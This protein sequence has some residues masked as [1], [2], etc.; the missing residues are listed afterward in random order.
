MFLKFFPSCKKI[1]TII[2]S[3]SRRMFSF[4]AFIKSSPK[5][6]V[7]FIG[8]KTI[9]CFTFCFYRLIDNINRCKTSLRFMLEIYPYNNKTIKFFF[10]TRRYFPYNFFAVVFC[11]CNI[12]EFLFLFVN[13]QK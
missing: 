8:K 2:A 9:Y 5:C 12:S 7:D 6:K 4:L 11:I 10:N 13:S 1:C 3:K